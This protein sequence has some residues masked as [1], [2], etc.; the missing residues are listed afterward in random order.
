[1]SNWHDGITRDCFQS[2]TLQLNTGD[3]PTAIVTFTFSTKNLT[4]YYEFH[5]SVVGPDGYGH[6]KQFD[7]WWAMC[8]P[9]GSPTIRIDPS[10]V[11]FNKYVK[12]IAVPESFSTSTIFYERL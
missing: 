5:P 7:L 10:G 1:M 8:L 12:A 3:P 4:F 2:G 9:G 6:N 11:G